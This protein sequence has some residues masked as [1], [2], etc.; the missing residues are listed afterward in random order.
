M[1]FISLGR[2]FHT[3]P[4]NKE[5]AKGPPLTQ[6]LGNGPRQDFVR[7]RVSLQWPRF[8]IGMPL[9]FNPCASS[10][11]RSSHSS[12]QQLA[13]VCSPQQNNPQFRIHPFF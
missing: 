3:Q 1:P 8:P 5:Q 12:L 6:G 4:T 7:G 2:E 9:P 11:P 13:W 10:N